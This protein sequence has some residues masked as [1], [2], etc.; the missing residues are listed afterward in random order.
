MLLTRS[1]STASPNIFSVSFE[2]ES[3]A[4]IASCARRACS[5]GVVVEVAHSVGPQKVSLEGRHERVRRIEKHATCDMRNCLNDQIRHV[6]YALAHLGAPPVCAARSRIARSRGVPKASAEVENGVG[7]PRAWRRSARPQHFA[8]CR[9]NSS[10]SSAPMTSTKS[11]ATRCPSGESKPARRKRSRSA[12]QKTAVAPHAR[13]DS[14]TRATASRLA[15]PT[16]L[17]ARFIRAL[18]EDRHSSPVC[19]DSEESA[20]LVCV[21]V[22]A[23]NAKHLFRVRE[24]PS[25]TSASTSIAAT[26]AGATSALADGR[27]GSLAS[28]SGCGLSASSR[29]TRRATMS[30]TC[31]TCLL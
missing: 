19:R 24:S 25:A 15:F 5:A 18:A 2:C 31:E 6:Y 30:T 14:A 26:A 17:Y 8:T 16:A 13:E 11:S 12:S 1:S 3:Y 28:R 21:S 23:A 10:G 22:A 27:E 9:Q 20:H 7:V 29:T 4:L